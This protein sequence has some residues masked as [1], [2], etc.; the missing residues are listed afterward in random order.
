MM[1]Q[2]P[3][4]SSLISLVLIGLAAP[5]VAAERKPDL[6]ILTATYN[7]EDTPDAFDFAADEVDK[8]FRVNASALV[9]EVKTRMLLGERSTRQSILDSLDWLAQNKAEDDLAVVYL[10]AHGTYDEKEGYTF[11]AADEPI[12]GYELKRSLHKVPGKVLLLIDTCYS[13][14]LFLKHEADLHAMPPNVIALCACKPEEKTWRGFTTALCEGVWGFADYNKDGVIEM[15]ELIRYVTERLVDWY[16]HG[17]SATRLRRFIVTT[18]P[19]MDLSFPV[20]RVSAALYAV[21]ADGR[22]WGALKVGDEGA[23]VLVHYVGS[24]DAEDEFV[25]SERLCRPAEAVKVRW[26]GDYYAARILKVENGE[27]R[28]HYLGYDSNTDETVAKPRVLPAFPAN[29]PPMGPMSKKPKRPGTR[30]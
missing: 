16:P 23:N 11:W 6:Y 17:E 5:A 4:L 7:E 25:P 24:P 14:S 2:R 27:C 30:K 19:G 22:W 10:G 12:F 15:G 9:G 29:L 21:E 20:A 8:A 13:G 18:P 3:T 26:K 1:K 28:V